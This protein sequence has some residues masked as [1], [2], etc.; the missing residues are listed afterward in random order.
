M[1]ARQS[2]LRLDHAVAPETKAGLRLTEQIAAQPARLLVR[3]RNSKESF[4]RGRGLHRPRRIRSLEQMRRV[5]RIARDAVEV[6]L[7]PVELRLVLAR[8]VT[9]HASRRVFRRVSVKREN[10]FLCRCYLRVVPF[11]VHHSFRVRLARTMARLTAGPVFRACRRCLR[12]NGL[13]EL[14]PL[15][16]VTV[17]TYLSARKILRLP[18]RR[19]PC[20]GGR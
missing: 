2:E 1:M 6:V 19:F 9:C 18:C 17:Q 11:A 13:V 3:L 7:R 4:L 8:H 10:Q 12:V 20:D 14:I 16:D 5:T 15:R